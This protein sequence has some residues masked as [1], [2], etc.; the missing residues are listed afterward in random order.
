MKRR[1]FISTGEVSGDWHGSILIQALQNSARQRDLELEILALGGDRMVAAG[2]T[3]LGNTVGIGS[4]GL[5]EALPYVLPTLLVQWRAKQ[6]LKKFPPDLVIL[7]DYVTPNIGMGY[8]TKR[9]LQVPVIYYIAPQEWVWSFNDKNTQAIAGFTDRILSIFPQEAKYYAEQGA[10]VKWVG[11]PLVDLMDRVP[12]RATA[13]QQLGISSE[14]LVVV[15]L[16][17][18]R[19]QE[20]KYLL[21][22]MLQTAKLIQ[23]Q[24]PQ[25]KFWLPLSLEKYRPNV[26]RLLSQ[27]GVKADVV[28][29]PSQLVIRAADLVLS[30]SGTVNLETALLNVPQVVIYRVSTVTAWIARHL[31]HFYIPFMSPPNLVQMKAIVP[32]FLQEAASPESVSQACLELLLNERSRQQMLYNYAEMR[33]CLGGNGAIERVATEILDALPVNNLN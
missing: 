10:Q 13:R 27:Y 31:L 8:F 1:I 30:K 23:A 2:A 26:E 17:A 32:E 3:L 14:D 21:P 25:V 20:L 29:H 11:H 15:L 24:L 28:S 5:V 19:S 9:Q 16:P 7:I 18:S 6:Q 4:I 33:N 12:D 22:V